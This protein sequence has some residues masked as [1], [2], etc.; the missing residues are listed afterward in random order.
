MAAY[1]GVRDRKGVSE[2]VWR[3]EEQRGRRPERY[4]VGGGQGVVPGVC[5][6]V[7]T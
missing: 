4:Q 1:L 6:L 2:L 5:G 3:E 7:R